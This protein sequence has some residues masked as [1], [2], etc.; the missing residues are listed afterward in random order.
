M[1][2]TGRRWSIGVQGIQS[3]LGGLRFARATSSVIIRNSARPRGRAR[4]NLR[5]LRRSASVRRSSA[6]ARRESLRNLSSSPAT[7]NG[8][9]GSRSAL[10]WTAADG[11]RGF[12]LEG[13]GTDGALA[14]SGIDAG[15]VSPQPSMPVTPADVTGDAHESFEVEAA[16]VTRVVC[17][18]TAVTTRL[19]HW[20][21]DAQ[22]P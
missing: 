20:L 9:S 10:G 13:C 11:R 19:R 17:A 5:S 4:A 14:P 22:T 18:G 3:D 21:C 2:H 8:P 12:G 15:A 16:Q 6:Q 1:R 7:C